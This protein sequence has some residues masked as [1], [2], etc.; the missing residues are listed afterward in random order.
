MI[1]IAA[2]WREFENTLHAKGLDWGLHHAPAQLRHARSTGHPRGA[3]VEHLL[4]ADYRAFVSEMGYPVVGFRYYD[5]AGISFLP[6]EAMASVSVELP[7]ADGARPRAVDGEPT[8]CRHAFF[9]GY[10]LSDI[11]G[12]SFG[13]ASDGS[14]PAVWLVEGSLPREECGTFTEWLSDAIARLEARIANLD[15]DR[16]AEMREENRDEDDPHRLLDYSLGGSYD[17]APY[18]AADLDLAWVESQNSDPYSYGLVDATGA[19][20]I[21]LGKRFLSVRPFRDGVAEVIVNAKASSY[22]GPWTR[23]RPDGSTIEIG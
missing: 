19:W 9:A 2:R 20:L 1:D 14:E 16:V 17:Q 6:P 12:Y 11:E 21:P 3:R 7:D 4:P 10:D 18:T 8:V 13:P 5:R 15:A 22:S 23:I